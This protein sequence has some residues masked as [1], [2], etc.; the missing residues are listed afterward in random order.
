MSDQKQPPR[1]V[2]VRARMRGFFDVRGDRHPR[3]FAPGDEF[4]VPENMISK[5]WMEVV[6]VTSPAPPAAAPSAP[7]KPKGGASVI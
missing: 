1:M 6:D 7:S 5:R 4:D 2:R 3:E